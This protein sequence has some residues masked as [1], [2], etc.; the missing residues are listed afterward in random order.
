MYNSL[1]SRKHFIKH[2][3]TQ[4]KLKP[5]YKTRKHIHKKR[6]YSRIRKSNK[7]YQ[8]RGGGYNYSV[9][10]N[11]LGTNINITDPLNTFITI[12]ESTNLSKIGINSHKYYTVYIT[13]DVINISNVSKPDERNV[14][15]APEN[16]ENTHIIPWNIYDT[17][18][19]KNNNI[20]VIS[21]LT[22]IPELHKYLTDPKPS[23]FVKMFFPLIFKPIMDVIHIS[24]NIELDRYKQITEAAI[25]TLNRANN[26]SKNTHSTLITQLKLPDTP[27]KS[28]E[29]SDK[30][31]IMLNLLETIYK[32]D[33][34]NHHPSYNIVKIYN[35]VV[36]NILKVIELL[37]C[38][39]THN[40][41][42]S[43]TIRVMNPLPLINENLFEYLKT[44]T[45]STDDNDINTEF[46]TYNPRDVQKTIDYFIKN[47]LETVPSD[48]Y[49]NLAKIINKIFDISSDKTVSNSSDMSSESAS[50]NGQST[51]KNYT[52]LEIDRITNQLF[53]VYF[54]TDLNEATKMKN[55]IID[56]I[57]NLPE[58]QS[59]LTISKRMHYYYE[60]FKL[61]KQYSARDKDVDEILNI[62]DKK[63]DTYIQSLN[64]DE[65]DEEDETLKD[66]IKRLSKL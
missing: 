20:T 50:D 4:N 7:T 10:H 14:S 42:I 63:K 59:I 9:F 26:Q 2:K 22:E 30:T 49:P 28:M 64:N 39:K 44:I 35:E 47:K 16:L 58:G 24:N 57:D 43:E 36:E 32:V 34:P 53:N 23:P 18:K 6:K 40:K 31:K 52:D 61:N 46:N 41:N 11:M 1:K 38:G 25:L 21:A 8:M 60:M 37:E 27:N 13:N 66:F 45:P 17:T 54:D 33:I 56:E 65:Q 12:Q 29:E 3:K 51:Q 5:K 15:K 48:E 19:A 55:R 62:I